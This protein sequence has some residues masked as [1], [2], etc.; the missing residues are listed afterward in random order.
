MEYVLDTI[1]EWST[2]EF[3]PPRRKIPTRE[4]HFNTIV[5]VLIGLIFSRIPLIYGTEPVEA[6][7][8]LVTFR[9]S[10]TWMQFGTQPFV[11]A[12]M[13]YSLIFDKGEHANKR[14]KALGLLFA[15]VMSLR[16]WLWEEHHWFCA[17]QLMTVAFGLVQAM[18]YL[19]DRGSVNLTTALIFAQASESIVSSVF[20][21]S[22]LWAIVLIAAVSWIETLVVTVPLTHMTRKSQTVSMPM[23]VM[24][25]STTGLVMYFTLIE[26]LAGVYQPLE[27]LSSN[28]IRVQTLVS[29]AALFVGLY[30]V[31]KQIPR[32]EERTGR[33]LIRAWQKE[34]FT[35]KG[36][37]SESRMAKYIQN[38]IDRNVFW[39]TIILFA[40]WCLGVLLKP[41]V[42]VTTLFILT[43]TAKQ[44]VTQPISSLWN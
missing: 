9:V 24:Y 18:T 5:A 12:S 27:I 40:L 29:A 42:S 35:I 16:W 7:D 23:P 32:V 17:F 31:N 22:I 33:H 3:E 6:A 39:N 34:K 2:Y 36:W 41:P 20:S 11:F 19:E 21:I 44:H 38:I 14:S 10:G 37:R 43:T 28:T 8:S 1:S 13:A 25:N 26:M 15:A 30:I 4:K